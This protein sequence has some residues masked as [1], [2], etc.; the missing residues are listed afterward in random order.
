M[1]TYDVVS[2]RK[3]SSV[4]H[5][6][7]NRGLVGTLANGGLLSR[8][9]LPKER[10]LEYVLHVNSAQRPEAS[11]DFDKSENW[12]DYVNLSISEINTR[13]LNVSKR[14]HNDS[15]VWWC[16]L[17]YCSEIMEHDGVYFAT[18]NNSYSLCKRDFGPAGLQALF[19]NTIYRKPG[20]SAL[21]ANRPSHL[22]TCDQAEVLYPRAVSNSFL[23]RIIVEHGVQQDAVFGWLRE[24]PLEGVDVLV[25]PRKFGGSPN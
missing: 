19:A 14:W 22:P 11:A 24:F 18:T 5:F 3:I 25:C 8:H 6:T 1:T 16:I 4:L 7:T 21:R 2:R 20:W 13:F 9:R 17:D 10:Y 23:Q 12:L 15:A